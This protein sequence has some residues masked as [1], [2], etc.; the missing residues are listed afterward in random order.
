[1]RENIPLNAAHPATKEIGQRAI[2]S[3]NRIDMSGAP[4]E[5]WMEARAI[6]SAIDEITPIIV[7]LSARLGD[8][9]A[10]LRE[11]I[12]RMVVHYDGDPALIKRLKGY[13]DEVAVLVD[14]NLLT[15]D[16]LDSRTTQDIINKHE[17]NRSN[18]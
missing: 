7:A 10:T 6:Q 17:G 4:M 1:M 3:G 18:G 11:S 13:G 16:F 12:L 15:V 8:L 14:W 2:D 5:A 9:N